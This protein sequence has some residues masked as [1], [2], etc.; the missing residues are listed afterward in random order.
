MS[1]NIKVVV[2]IKHFMVLDAI[3]RGVEDVGRI[4]RVTKADKAEVEMM[5]FTGMAMNP[6]ESAIA[7][8]AAN[9]DAQAAG[10]D[11]HRSS[12]TEVAG[13]LT[14]EQTFPALIPAAETLV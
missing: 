8:D 9:A 4:A 7:R 6:A 2:T 13:L 5:P 1:E 3:S 10:A 12:M 11:I 14:L